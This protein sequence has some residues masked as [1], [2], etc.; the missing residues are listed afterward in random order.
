MVPAST[1]APL[2]TDPMVGGLRPSGRMLDGAKV[3]RVAVNATADRFVGDRP[4]EV[5]IRTGGLRRM[6]R[7]AAPDGGGWI[8]RNAQF[9]RV[10]MAVPAHERSTLVIGAD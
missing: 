8:L 6:F 1:V 3:S 7:C 2:A 10:T 9:P 4:S 5:T